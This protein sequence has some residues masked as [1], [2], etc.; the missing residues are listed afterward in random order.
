MSWLGSAAE[1]LDEGAAAPYQA[2]G[3]VTGTTGLD[4]RTKQV[5]TGVFDYLNISRSYLG[6]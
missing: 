1:A 6:D 4:K 5:V 2:L 3:E